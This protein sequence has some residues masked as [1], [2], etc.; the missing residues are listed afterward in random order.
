M[1]TI[2]WD[3]STLAADRRATG[4][5]FAYTITKI[6]RCADGRLVGAAG[7]VSAVVALLDWQADGRAGDPPL[8]LS[9]TDWHDMIEVEP[10]GSVWLWGDHGRYRIHDRT[11]AIGS[12]ACY[13]RAAMACDRDAPAAIA[14]AS[15]FDPKTGPDVDTLELLAAPAP[16][17]RR[18][19]AA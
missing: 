11:A 16:S 19:R 5:G 12:G 9:S 17:R 3:G 7:N 1:T 10:D 15:L 2:A 8:S 18:V 6:R 4:E 14:V 13:A